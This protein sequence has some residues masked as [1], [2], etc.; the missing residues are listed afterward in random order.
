MGIASP[1]RDLETI[2]IF[3]EQLNKDKERMESQQAQF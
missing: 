3:R 2:E 1:Q